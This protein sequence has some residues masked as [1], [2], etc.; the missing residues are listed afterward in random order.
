MTGERA[1]LEANVDDG[2]H[3]DFHLDELDGKALEVAMEVRQLLDK[4]LGGLNPSQVKVACSEH[5][6]DGTCPP[7]KDDCNKCQETLQLDGCV[8]GCKLFTSSVSY[9][10]STGGHNGADDIKY[11]NGECKGLF[12]MLFDG[13]IL[14]DFLSM[15]G[16]SAH[17]FP[18]SF[19]RLRQSIESIAA[20]HG[21]IVED[22]TSYAM[23]FY[24]DE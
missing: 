23:T 18:D 10:F 13:G 8:S 6:D 15:N 12:S 2:W 5:W 14:Y 11:H 9:A 7:P 24:E 21:C 16:D 17:L 22:S 19:W 1:C 20:K 3:E 4:E